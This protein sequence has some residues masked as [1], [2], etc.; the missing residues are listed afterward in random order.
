MAV[1]ADGVHLG[2]D[3]LSP[4]IARRLAGERIIIGRSTHGREELDRSLTEPIDYVSAG[5]VE[6]TPTK[7][8]REPTGL[9]Y[10]EYATKTACVPVFVTGGVTPEKIPTLAAAGARHFVVVRYILDAKDAFAASQA[11][12]R[13]IDSALA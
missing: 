12:R 13:A 2:Q 4:L 5:P 7:A 6:A 9:N 8:G 10:L 1:E 11:L 3:D